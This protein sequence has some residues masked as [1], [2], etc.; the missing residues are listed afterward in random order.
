MS[1]ALTVLNSNPLAT[2]GIGLGSDM[3]SNLKPVSLELVSKSSTKEGAIPG[4]IRNTASGEHMDSMRVVLFQVQAQREWYPPYNPAVQQEKICFSLDNVRPHPKAKNP[5]AMFCATCP[6]GDLQWKVWEANGKQAKDLPPCQKYWHTSLADRK[7][8]MFYYLNIKGIGVKGFQDSMQKGLMNLITMEKANVVMR[9]KERGYAP[10]KDKFGNVGGF[11]PV[12]G[13][14]APEGGQLPPLPLP[15]L[16]DFSFTIY[17]H[18][19]KPG[20]AFAIGCKD[21][22]LMNEKEKAEFGSLYAEYC[23]RRNYNQ[24]QPEVEPELTED[25]VAYVAPEVI[26]GAQGE[27]LPPITI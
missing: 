8:Q 17:S 13:F 10:I 21:F 23:E 18:Q 5:P 7:T 4:K 27:V 15:N 2:G 9:N 25:Q 24:A 11:G 20:G 6:K 3:F 26:K 14:K 19:P 1:E 22:L 12:E 16:F